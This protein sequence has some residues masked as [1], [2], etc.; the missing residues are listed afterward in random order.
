[1]HEIMH[2]N[3]A[4]KYHLINSNFRGLTLIGNLD[5]VTWTMKQHGER[6]I[7]Q[8]KRYSNLVIVEALYSL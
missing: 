1:M 6:K 8:H 3:D 4:W 7:G 2:F 5:T